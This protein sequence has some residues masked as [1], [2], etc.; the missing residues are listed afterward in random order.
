MVD[1]GV[2]KRLS[3]EEKKYS[4]PIFYISHY[5]VMKADSKSIPCR[6][7]LNSSAKFMNHTLND[8]WVKRPDLINNLLGILLRFRR[9][10][11]GVAGDISKMYHTVKISQLDQHTHRFLWRNMQED[12]QPDIYV[13]TSVSFGDKPAGAIASLALRKTAELN[14]V[15]SPFAAQTIIDN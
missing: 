15:I 7:V 5:E 1:S 13:I 9:N 4:G 2:T 12:K 6:I 14:S 10:V 8:Y 3:D 11:V